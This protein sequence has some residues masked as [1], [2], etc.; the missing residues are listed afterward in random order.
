MYKTLVVNEAIP[1]VFRIYPFGNV[2]VLAKAKMCK[3]HEWSFRQGGKAGRGHE[4][5]GGY[6][7]IVCAI[8]LSKRLYVWPTCVPTLLGLN[9]RFSGGFK[10]FCGNHSCL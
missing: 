1:R 8:V 4:M 9:E 7:D 3:G 10:E 2:S 5:Y 6:F